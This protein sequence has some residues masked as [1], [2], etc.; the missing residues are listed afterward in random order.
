MY[1]WIPF[2]TYFIFILLVFFH[3]RSWQRFP[4]WGTRLTIISF[5][6]YIIAV[7]WLCLTPAHF[8]IPSTQKILFHFHGIPYN[9]I[10]FQGFSIEY[11]LN[12]VM[13]FP[14]GV[15]LYLF[16]YRMPFERVILVG[17]CFSLFIESNQFIWDYFLN[18]QRLADV[19]DLITNTL[20]AIIGFS[21]MIILYQ[22]GWQKFLQRFMIIRH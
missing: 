18:L 15:Y 8:D 21:L 4:D 10:P 2:V 17:F 5:L 16:N 11:V 22:N 20:G 6:V 13:T 7:L 19:D 14:L 3:S 9:A 12:I 1:A